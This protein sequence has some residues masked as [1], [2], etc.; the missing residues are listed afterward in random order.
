MYIVGGRTAL[1][2]CVSGTV[3]HCIQKWQIEAI[4]WNIQ[5]WK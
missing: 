2:K 5:M 1:Q 4:T 3:K